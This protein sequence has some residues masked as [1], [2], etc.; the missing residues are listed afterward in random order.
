MEKIMIKKE[1]Y[2]I[3]LSSALTTFSAF[4][5]NYIPQIQTAIQKGSNTIP[6]IVST[7]PYSAAELQAMWAN[8]IAPAAQIIFDYLILSPGILLIVFYPLFLDASL[9]EEMHTDLLILAQIANYQTTLLFLR[10][11]DQLLQL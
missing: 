10:L 1:Y 4:G 11:M 7:A 5:A 3:M 6:P 8:E 2:K 9:L